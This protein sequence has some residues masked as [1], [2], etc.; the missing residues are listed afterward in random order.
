M[1]SFTLLLFFFFFNYISGTELVVLGSL[2]C[3]WFSDK[4]GRRSGFLVGCLLSILGIGLQYA[5]SRH[6]MLLVGKI[7]SEPSPTLV[8][9]I[10]RF[11]T[12]SNTNPIK[13]SDKRHRPRL[14]PLPSLNL[15]LRNLPL[16][17]PPH[18]NSRN[19]LLHEQRATSR[20]GNRGIPNRNSYTGFL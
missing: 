15:H 7:V 6:G 18:P 11:I 19:K 9:I 17:T 16:T 8:S 13:I 20:H 12:T 5:A 14:L 1:K 3:G 4:A 2:L 10:F